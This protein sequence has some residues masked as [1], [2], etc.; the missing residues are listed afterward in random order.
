VQVGYEA[1]GV[2]VQVDD[3]GPARVDGTGSGAN[4]SP[5]AGG[6]DGPG[7]E[8]PR[9]GNGITGMSERAHALG[10]T[11]DAGPRS[12]GGFRVSAFLPA[13][14]GSGMHGVPDSGAGSGAYES[15][16]AGGIR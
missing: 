4:G 6:N 10:G 7:H 12:D 8:L 14:D 13:P 1:A 9:G 3:D 15:S 5:Q 2:R 16:G 11:L